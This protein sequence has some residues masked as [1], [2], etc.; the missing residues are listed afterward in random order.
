VARNAWNEAYFAGGSSSGTGVSVAAGLAMFGLGSDTGGSVRYPAA[1]N[2]LFGL[3]PTYGRLSRAGILPNSFSF[4]AAGPL[5]RTVRDAALIMQTIAGVDPK[6]PTS[7]DRPVPNYTADLDKGVNGLRIGYLR[8]FHMRDY[9]GD[10][11]VVRALDGAVDTLRRLGAQIV[12]VDVPYSAQDYRLV[13]RVAGGVESLAIHE[14]DFRERSHL[15]GAALRDKF[16]GAMTVSGVD[17]VQATRWRREMTT[18]TNAAIAGCDAI[19]CAGP[20]FRVPM[21]SEEPAMLTFMAGSGTCVFN[22]TGHPAATVPTGID[23]RGLPTCMQ[24]VGK[25]WDEAM[26]MRVAHAYEQASDFCRRVP[27]RR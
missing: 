10:A 22:V 26:V 13:T 9:Q 12:E 17:Y 7:V 11:E 3:K 6:D 19:I 5:T 14:K 1:V 2:G 23:D 8:R 15:M 25:F 20:V 16:L 18:A 4:D 27:V 24:V 21:R